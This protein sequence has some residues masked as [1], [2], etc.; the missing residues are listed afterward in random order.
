LLVFS[1]VTDKTLINTYAHLF[2]QV[3]TFIYLAT[4]MSTVQAFH[5]Q[6]HFLHLPVSHSSVV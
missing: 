6:K 5:W 1:T 4:V 2:S 3:I